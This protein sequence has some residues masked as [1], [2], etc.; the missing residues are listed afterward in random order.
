MFVVEHV[1]SLVCLLLGYVS[2]VCLPQ[3]L[4]RERNGKT[5]P[6]MRVV[7]GMVLVNQSHLD[8]SP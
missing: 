7:S 3:C 6:L 8:L 1:S 4:T 5:C 2:C